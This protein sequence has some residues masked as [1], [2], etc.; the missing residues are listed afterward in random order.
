ME[1]VAADLATIDLNS[2]LYKYE[3]GIAWAIRNV[4]DDKLEVRPSRSG[5]DS[6][7]TV[8]QTSAMWDDK[9]AIRKDRIDRY[10]WNE[11]KGIYFDYNTAKQQQTTFESVTCFYALWCGVASPAQ[12]A[13]LV[14]E[15][16]PMFE[17]TG[18]LSC[19][20]Q[21]SRGPTGPGI[22]TRQ[23]DYPFGWAPH[24]MLAWDGL[25]R[26]G[27]EDE[28]KRLVYRWLHMITQVVVDH[29]GAITEKYNVVTTARNAHEVNAEY[30]N[31]GLDFEG[32]AREG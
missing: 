20:S 12:A 15:G 11:E 32:V 23:W 4:F 29:N 5:S 10:L 9:A 3:T 26:Y 8:V 24:Q 7:T 31:Q 27:Y 16:L 6:M 25:G 28:A 22:P 21:R 14:S 18:G 19:G 17:Q 1:G 13:S 30:G 2:L